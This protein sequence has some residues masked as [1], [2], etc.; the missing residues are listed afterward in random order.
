[1]QWVAP[2]QSPILFKSWTQVITSVAPLITFA[3]I[4]M[5]YADKNLWLTIPFAVLASLFLPRVFLIQHDCG[6]G[7][8]FKSKWANDALGSLC[9][10]LSF[11]P[12]YYWR[13]TH[14]I[15]HASSGDLSRRGIG[16]VYTLTVKEYLN[17]SSYERFKYRCYRNPILFFILGPLYLFF[18][19]FRFPFPESRHWPKERASVWWTN[20]GIALIL[21]GAW[22]AFGLYGP[23]IIALIAA[24]A[25]PI[26][27]WLFYVQHQFEEAYW[28]P[29]ENWDFE[30]AALQG[31]TFYNL[32]AILHWFTAN[33]GFHHIHHLSPR[34]PNYRLQDCHEK[35]PKFQQ[36]PTL[37]L[38]ASFSTVFLKLWDEDQKRLIRFKDVQSR[39]LPSDQRPAP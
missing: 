20:L 11:T 18:I 38:R 9:G 13:K 27:V 23:L 14:A 12:Y 31:S 7:S 5:Y 32:P 35:N 3:S 25:A 6:H 16:D 26:A 17:L 36:V 33:I 29:H 1:M 21:L 8:F 24:L 2:Y 19:Q 28:A 4:A 10:V 22:F 39:D 15:H 37:T 30:Q 34:I